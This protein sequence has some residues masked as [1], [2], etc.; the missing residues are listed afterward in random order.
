MKQMTAA[1]VFTLALTPLVGAQTKPTQTEIDQWTKDTNPQVLESEPCKKIAWLLDSERN[2]SADLVHQPI[3]YALGWW[4]R[5]FVEGAVYMIGGA[6]PK[7]AN[8][9][10]L[11]V[12]VVV[13]HI[14]TY[15]YAH[16]TET[17][18]D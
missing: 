9:F 8:E 13:A 3:H 10:G 15:C 4:G 17:P 14:A 11:S 7:K 16:D 12:E 5:G 2:V 1:L 18:F 6:A